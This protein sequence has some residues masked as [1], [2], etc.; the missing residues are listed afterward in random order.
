MTKTASTAPVIVTRKEVERIFVK[1]EAESAIQEAAARN[2]PMEQAQAMAMTGAIL[3]E[4]QKAETAP[5][6]IGSW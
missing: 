3:R 1:K 6:P 5:G 2:S 4:L